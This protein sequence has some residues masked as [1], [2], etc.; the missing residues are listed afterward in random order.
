MGRTS[1]HDI[2]KN[3]QGEVPPPVPSLPTS[4]SASEPIRE[5]S[6][7]PAAVKKARPMSM[8]ARAFSSGPVENAEGV[9][10]VPTVAQV[11]KDEEAKAA[12]KVRHD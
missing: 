6:A 4:I 7:K 2:V 9:A 8:M 1:V 11:S 10:P 5:I 12:K 3:M